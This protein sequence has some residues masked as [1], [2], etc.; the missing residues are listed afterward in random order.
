MS[1]SKG[2]PDK[3]QPH[4]IYLN[5]RVFSERVMSQIDAYEQELRIS[6]EACRRFDEKS[7]V[8]IKG[9]NS[10]ATSI[11]AALKTIL[12]ETHP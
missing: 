8:Y 6:P 11:S 3:K 2:Q 12:E 7:K 1:A 10:D 4:W 5:I 9:L